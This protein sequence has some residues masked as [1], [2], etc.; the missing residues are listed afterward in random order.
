MRKHIT[1]ALLAIALIGFIWL[2]VANIS[3]SHNKLKVRDIQL[4]SKESDLLQ[5]EN[6]FNLLNKELEQKNLDADKVKELENQKQQLQQQLDKAQSDLQAKAVRQAEEKQKLATAAQNASGSTKV[7]AAAGC[8]TGNQYKDYIY[9]H[10]SG[11]RPEAV[12]SIGCRGIGQACPG[13]KLPCGA[14]FACQDAYFTN[15]AMARYGSWEA[16]YRFWVANRWW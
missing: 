9:S 5:L 1:T 16:A 7:S 10:E 12:N 4:K 2:G 11:C 8:N 14:D 6:K 3:S 13:T 15:Y